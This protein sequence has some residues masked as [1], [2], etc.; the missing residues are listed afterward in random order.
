M[1]RRN[2]LRT[3]LAGAAGLSATAV[4][5]TAAQAAAPVYLGRRR[6]DPFLDRDVLHVGVGRGL[7]RKI[8]FSA[9]GND[10]FVYDVKVDYTVGGD[11]HFNTRLKIAQGTSSRKLNLRYNKRFVQDVTFRYG[12]LPNGNG[13]AFV[14]VWGWR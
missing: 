8:S 7:F 3:A 10:V 2:F 14:E 5:G 9:N 4:L 11:Q 12:K 6:V 13:A 1:D